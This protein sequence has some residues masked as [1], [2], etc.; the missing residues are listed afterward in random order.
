A[1]ASKGSGLTPRQVV[2]AEYFD[3]LLNLSLVSYEVLKDKPGAKRMYFFNKIV[4]AFLGKDQKGQIEGA[5]TVVKEYFAEAFANKDFQDLLDSYDLASPKNRER[6]K[7]LNYNYNP[8]VAKKE[9]LLSQAVKAVASVFARLRNVL[10][11]DQR[12][13]LAEA[14]ALG[15]NLQFNKFIPGRVAQEISELSFSHYDAVNL[16]EGEQIDPEEVLATLLKR[17]DK[18]QARLNEADRIQLMKK[19]RKFVGNTF[20]DKNP[21]GEYLKGSMIVLYFKSTDGFMISWKTINNS[22]ETES[23]RAFFNKR[24]G[25]VFVNTNVK[26][27]ES[28]VTLAKPYIFQ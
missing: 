25:Q 11:R 1:G 27:T 13:L 23:N 5:I 20:S 28:D 7:E 10:T 22:G 16:Y 6:L 12:T 15:S 3:R 19:M 18:A 24:G 8:V 2:N 4:P 21:Y 17:L 9:S 26:N 14:F